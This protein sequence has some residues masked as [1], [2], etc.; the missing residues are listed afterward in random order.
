MKPGI[1]GVAA[2]CLGAVTICCGGKAWAER[3]DSLRLVLLE[4]VTIQAQAMRP[5]QSR[6]ELGGAPVERALQELGVASVRRGGALTGDLALGPFLRGDV[7]LLLDGERHP[8]ACPNRMDNAS[9]RVNPADLESVDVLRNCCEAGCGLGGRVSVER[10]VPGQRPAVD[11]ELGGSTLA[12]GDQSLALGV[13]GHGLRLSGRRVWGDGYEDGEGRGFQDLFPYSAE[14]DYHSD[15]IA[16]RALRGDWSAGGSWTRSEDVPFPYLQMDERETDHWA[17]H[18]AWRRHKLY[19]NGTHHLM[20]NGLRS[21]NGVPLAAPSMVSDAVNSMLGMSGPGYHVSW[22]RWELENHFI[23]ST[24]SGPTRL[25][26]DMIP[27]LSQLSAEVHRSLAGPAGWTASLRLGVVR[28]QVG[29][30]EEMSARVEKLTPDPDTGRLFLVHGF[31][32]QHALRMGPVHGSLL[33]ETAGEDPALESLWMSLKKPGT[34]AWWLGNPE[35][36]T[37]L[38][39]TARTRLALGGWEA[40]LALSRVQRYAT[41]AS[42]RFALTDSTWQAVQTWRETGADLAEA[43]LS[44]R[45]SWLATRASFVWGRETGSGRALPEMSPASVESTLRH[46]WL[47]ADLWLRHTWTAAQRRVGVALQERPTGAW[48]RLDLGLG[49]AWPHLELGLEVEN[50]LDHAFHQHLSYARNPFSAGMP[51]PEPGRTLRLRLRAFS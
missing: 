46:N 9:T 11:L 4:P 27:A 1:T 48:N 7:E 10:R 28:D 41:M 31:A 30:E 15:E 6:A 37:A 44:W 50:L 3:P 45:G 49:R 29:E 18:L 51:V 35:L 5:G 16:L 38:R 23:M 32:L 13:E 12:A 24:P 20:D 26:N 14:A 22:Y 40:E 34:N 21:V 2:L 17:A 33:L 36:E 39:H 42:A 47:G 8:A 25:E 43:Q 19:A